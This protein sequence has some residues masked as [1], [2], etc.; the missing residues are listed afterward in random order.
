MPKTWK[1]PLP[2]GSHVA[3]NIA[4]GMSVTQGVIAAAAY[5]DGWMYRIDVTGGDDC[6][7][8]RTADG[9]WRRWP[10]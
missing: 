8:H 4:Q 2:V 10:S 3:I 1:P 9:H 7:M 5:D 6:D